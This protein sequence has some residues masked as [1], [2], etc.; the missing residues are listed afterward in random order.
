MCDPPKECTHK[1]CTLEFIVNIDPDTASQNIIKSC[2][3]AAMS[4][5]ANTTNID[6]KI[7]YNFGSLTTNDMLDDIKKIFLTNLPT[8]EK[9][10]HLW[11]ERDDEFAFWDDGSDVNCLCK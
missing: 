4:A 1:D 5:I 8:G 9:K 2:A 6:G 7:L 11:L 10:V 3:L